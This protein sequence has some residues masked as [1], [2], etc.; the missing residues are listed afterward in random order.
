MEE[1]EVLKEV[2]RDAGE[3]IM[4]YYSKDV[5][6]SV[7]SDF[8]PV[9]EADLASERVLLQ[10]L[11]KFGYG[12]LSEE[13]EDNLGRLTYEKIWVIDPLDGT[14]DF[15][16][17][18]GEFSVM[19]GLVERGEIV[20][21]AVYEPV[22]RKLYYAMKGGGAF[23]EVDGGVAEKLSVSKISDFSKVRMLISRF[24]LLEYE[25]GLAKRLG[26]NNMVECGSAGIKICRIAEGNAELYINSSD[27]TFEWDICAADIVLTEAGG[28]IIDLNG[29]RF[30]YNKKES[31][32][33][34]GVV[35]SNGLFLF[36]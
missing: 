27:K 16:G 12:V 36:D 14:K 9:T 23:L 21:G 35:A 19:V 24:H 5:D 3:A 10:G 2:I 26:I 29:E 7:K 33:E 18:T 22:S 8:S 25:K 30:S 17:R 1:L 20:M 6:V 15:I 31:R 28:K 32:N 4:A 34:E 11:G 13:T